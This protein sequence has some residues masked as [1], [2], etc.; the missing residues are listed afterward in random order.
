M[1]CFINEAVVIEGDPQ[2]HIVST[3]STTNTTN[4]DDATQY[5]EDTVVECGAATMEDMHTDN[6]TN[7]GSTDDITT[8]T[9]NGHVLQ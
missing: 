4:Y 5:S 3:I 8:A 7:S 2:P 1:F 6:Y 9:L